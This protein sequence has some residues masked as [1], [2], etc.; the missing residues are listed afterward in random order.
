MNKTIT[1][2]LGLPREIRLESLDFI[3]E[4]NFLLMHDTSIDISKSN[5][6]IP[7]IFIARGFV[8]DLTSAPFLLKYVYRFTRCDL[9]SLAHDYLYSNTLYSLTRKEKDVVFRD[10]LESSNVPMFKRL[11]MYYAVRMFGWRFEK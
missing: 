2:H 6:N 8:T 4:G 11:A 10:I 3:Q 5:T 1:N 7:F 9:A